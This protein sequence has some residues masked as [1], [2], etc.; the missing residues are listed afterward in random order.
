MIERIESRALAEGVTCL[1]LETQD[2]VRRSLPPVRDDHRSRHPV[3]GESVVYRSPWQLGRP[4][5]PAP[6]LGEHVAEI[7]AEYGFSEADVE[8]PR[9]DRVFG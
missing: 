7:M 5:R 6:M 3:V 8:S 1:V 9:S 2:A 4:S